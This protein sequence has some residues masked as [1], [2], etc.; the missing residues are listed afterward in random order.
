MSHSFRTA[1][2]AALMV[3]ECAA[4]N[5]IPSRDVPPAVFGLKIER[6][7]PR[8]LNA[9][10]RRDSVTVGLDNQVSVTSVR[11]LKEV[12]TTTSL[13]INSYSANLSLGT[14]ELRVRIDTGSSDLWVNTKSSRVCSLGS[15]PCSE[16]GTYNAN[17]SSSYK[18][19]S[20][21]F[22]VTYADGSAALGDY[23][24][25]TLSIGDKNLD[26]F[27]F[28]IGY[29]S[30]TTSGILGLGYTANEAQVNRNNKKPYPNLPQAL[31]DAKLINSNA[32]SLWLDDLQ[33]STGSI[34]FGGVDTD[35][36]TGSLQTLP[37]QKVQ[38]EFA[39]LL[40]SISGLSISQ[41]GNNQSTT[42]DLPTAAILDSGSTMTYLPDD[43]T[44]EIYNALN[45]QFSQRQGS[46]FCSCDLANENITVGFTF[47]SPTISVPISELVINPNED[48][49]QD[50][51]ELEKRQGLSNQ[52]SLC[53]FGIAPTG[54]I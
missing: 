50:R 29:Q 46:G 9:L 35:K 4:L 11:R 38:G 13:Q 34:L 24:T 1:L 17:S 44:S 23:A 7:G 27:Q 52:D 33:S 16:S 51:L 41:S 39:E 37:I 21:D 20:D 49:S 32:Y 12:L 8:H 30:S 53:I 10:R 22:N 26:E 15:D 3:F 42:S 19:L 18:F 36:Y 25:D 47:T 28:G 2:V 31:V 45:V 43:L 48:I 6:S 54:G 40:L 5:F 14:Q